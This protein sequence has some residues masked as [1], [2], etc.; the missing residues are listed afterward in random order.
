[1]NRAVW[2]AQ[3]VTWTE[4]PYADARAKG[5]MALFGEKYGDVVRVVEVDGVS[6]ELCGGTHVRNTSEIGLLVIVSETGV[7]S[8]VRRIEA[9]TGPAAFAH[10]K[11]REQTLHHV[12]ELLKAPLDGVER[13][14][15]Q[16]LD[17]RRG[18]ERKLDEAMRGGG[19]GDELQRLV[20]AAQPIGPDGARLVIGTVTATDMKALQA[21]GDALREQVRSGAGVLAT[22]LE[23]GKGAL[24]VVV[25]D[26][27]RARGLLADSVVRALATLA[28][29]RGGG[30][31]HMAQAGIPDATALAR[32]LEEAPG[33]VARL[34]GTA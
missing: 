23:D 24:L 31:A 33:V 11:A 6:M 21:M 9:L 1:V 27:L 2:K 29:G 13:R 19:G 25:S 14:V 26:D 10:L 4:M 34:L 16:L 30:K 12:S 17:E 3:P 8:G 22:R 32:A 18:L 7:A 5:A 20:A 28:G 15:Q